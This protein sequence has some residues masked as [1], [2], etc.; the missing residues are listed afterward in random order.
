[1]L[2]LFKLAVIALTMAAVG[3]VAMAQDDKAMAKA[4]KAR[5]GYMQVLGFNMGPLGAMAKGK[6][7]YDAAAATVAA[8]NLKAASEI[9]LG[10][11]WPAGSD[12]GALGD[13]T[14]ALPKIWES[15]DEFGQKWKDFAEAAAA[16]AAVA[17]NGSEEMVAAFKPVGKS[18]GGCHKPFRAAKKK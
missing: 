10:A 7:P 14:R 3:G 6:A 1:M 18:C 9:H 4:L 17:G 15:S 16:L 13:E 11:A 12:N 8:N 5:K 2:K